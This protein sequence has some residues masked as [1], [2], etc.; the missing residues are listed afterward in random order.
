MR[1]Y[2]LYINGIDDVAPFP[3]GSWMHIRGGDL[4]ARV[5]AMRDLRI[6]SLNT[7]M[8]FM[9]RNHRVSKHECQRIVLDWVGGGR[10][11]PRQ[12]SVNEW[13][14]FMDYIQLAG[15]LGGIDVA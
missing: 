1:V 14:T 9:T 13:Q 12:V 10:L 11:W 5:E 6:A 7:R 4:R 2:D 15:T 8:A 3:Q